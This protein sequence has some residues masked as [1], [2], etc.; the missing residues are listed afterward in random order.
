MN[1]YK[2]HAGDLQ[3]LETEQGEDCPSCNWNDADWLILPGGAMLRKDLG[4]G[5]FQMN[6]DM[7]LTV[8]FAQFSDADPAAYP[9][10]M[11]LKDMMLETPCTYLGD[12]Y[13]I[14]SVTIMGNG[15]QLHIEAN[16]LNQGAG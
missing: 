15:H 16:A 8:L 4:A 10:A 9:D 5:G 12:D 1:I 2:I 11:T 6:S 13:K 3:S 14:I 7:R